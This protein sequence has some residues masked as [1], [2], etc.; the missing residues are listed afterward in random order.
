MNYYEMILFFIDKKREEIRNK[1]LNDIFAL[2]SKNITEIS[3]IL[4]IPPKS[5]RCLF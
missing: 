4:E 2:Y 1:D 3:K 5:I